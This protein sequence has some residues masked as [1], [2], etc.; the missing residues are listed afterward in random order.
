MLA[1][2]RSAVSKSRRRQRETDRRHALRRSLRAEPLEGR[3]LMTGD[4]WVV[5][6]NI[7]LYTT[8]G[9]NTTIPVAAG[10]AGSVYVGATRREGSA[11]EFDICLTKYSS[12]GKRAWMNDLRFPGYQYIT[13][14]AV[15]DDG[16]YIVGG[17]EG[18]VNFDP[19][20]SAAGQFESQGGH[21]GYLA[22]YDAGGA[23][24]WARQWGGAG[25]DRLQG[26]A[27][28]DGSVY[29]TGRTDIFVRNKVQG[30][31]LVASMSSDGVVRWEQMVGPISGF[32][33]DIAVFVP[34][35]A[36]ASIY[37]F[38]FDGVRKWIETA[39]G[40]EAVLAWAL[41]VGGMTGYGGLAVGTADTSGSPVPSLY[42]LADHG[43]KK[44]S[45]TG[46]LL[47]STPVE[48]DAYP[49]GVTV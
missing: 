42:V 41:D 33:T 44:I 4:S 8:G 18:S 13:D 2:I 47:W 38:G 26:V 1:K 22:K 43:L 49:W 27:V 30:E 5:D 6:T 34:P 36:P 23:F 45:D 16:V 25:Y 29:V 7:P 48:M 10:D 35:S 28:S 31:Q 20:R 19:A 46:T 21:D 14:V 15:A 39:D 37:T 3:L 40:R 17:F 9:G 24:L 32:P 12:D 11:T